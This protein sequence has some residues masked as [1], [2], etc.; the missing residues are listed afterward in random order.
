MTGQN[1]F[2]KRFKENF[3]RLCANRN[4]VLVD[5][6]MSVD[7]QHD[8]S[9]RGHTGFNPKT[10]KRVVE[11]HAFSKMIS[12]LKDVVLPQG[13][14]IICVC[15]SGRHR[16]PATAAMIAPALLEGLYDGSEG[17]INVVHLQSLTHWDN[18]C[19][20]SCPDCA[21][22]AGCSK[23]APMNKAIQEVLTYLPK[24]WRMQR[25]EENR[26]KEETMTRRKS[27]LEYGMSLVNPIEVYEDVSRWRRD[28]S[29][30]RKESVMQA[31]A[32][33]RAKPEKPEEEVVPLPDAA[34]RREAT[35]QARSPTKTT[36]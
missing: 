30:E 5:C 32:K 23:S 17:L 16:S 26:T 33:P 6:T 13:N 19:D 24:S 2:L 4:I 3:S 20:P 1:V 27:T 35:R 25:Q 18:L 15:K 14:L 28:A 36:R 12:A 9:M 21:E 11:S 31:K 22:T 8:K 34:E 7:P 29:R 10:M